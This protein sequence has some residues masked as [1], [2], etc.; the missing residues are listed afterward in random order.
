[1]RLKQRRVIVRTTKGAKL[2]ERI[3]IDGCAGLHYK[4]GKHEEDFTV[5]QLVEYVVG[6]PVEQI[7]YKDK[8]NV[9][10]YQKTE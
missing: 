2:G 9:P 1:M 8:G 6:I 4:S 7:I 3:M 10:D 5:E